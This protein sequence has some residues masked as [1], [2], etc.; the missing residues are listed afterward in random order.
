MLL[1]G[2]TGGIGSGKSQVAQI[3]KQLGAYLIDAD[4]LAHEAVRPDGPVLK[5]IVE[6]FGPDL[7]NPDGTLDRAKLARLVFAD[8]EKR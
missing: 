5:R 7:L 6:V 1:V 2:L 8:S 4:E 3:F